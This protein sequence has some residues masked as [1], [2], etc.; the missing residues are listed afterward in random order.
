[1]RLPRWN[2]K[3]EDRDYLVIIAPRGEEASWAKA[4]NYAGY[5]SL[6]WVV[7][8]GHW[9]VGCQRGMGYQVPSFE[10][11]DAPEWAFDNM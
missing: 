8:K 4:W 1:M 2:Q 10:D 5:E 11:V 6:E 7:R 3:V 9:L